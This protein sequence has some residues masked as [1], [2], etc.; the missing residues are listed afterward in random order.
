M[1]KKR[2]EELRQK[3]QT[4]EGNIQELSEI[5]IE[6]FLSFS[7]HIKDLKKQM[8]DLKDEQE[9]IYTELKQ[10]ANPV[11]TIIEGS[12]DDFEDLFNEEETK[13]LVVDQG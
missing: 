3:F 11:Y 9:K 7:E 10:L 8:N 4:N 5:L 6:F 2:L 13:E 1:T 12:P